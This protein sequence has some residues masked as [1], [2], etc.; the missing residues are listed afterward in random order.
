MTDWE[1]VIESFPGGSHNFPRVKGPPA[2]PEEAADQ[3]LVHHDAAHGDRLARPLH[4]LRPLDAV[5]DRRAEPA[6][7]AVPPGR[8]QRLRRHRLVR[9]RHDQ[10]PDLRAVRRSMQSR[11]S[12]KPPNLHFDRIDL[13]T[14]GARLGPQRRPAD[15]QLAGADLPDQV[16]DRYRDAEADLLQRGPLTAFG[17]G[18]FEGT[19]HYF[20]VGARA[21]RPLALA[22]HPREARREHVGFPDLRGDVLWLPDLLEVTNA[23]S[24]FL[25][26][27]ADFDYRILS[28]D[29]KSGPKRAVWDV[30]YH[31]LRSRAAHRLPEHRG[32]SAGRAAPPAT[33]ARMADGQWAQLRGD[34]ESRSRRP[35]ACSLMTRDLSRGSRG[36]E[37]SHP[38]E[39]GPFNPRAPLGYVPIAGQSPTSSIPTGS[40]SAAAGWPPKTY[41]SFDGRTAYYKASRSRSM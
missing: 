41:V 11:F 21:E 19:F 6:G 16:E 24:E 36:A 1:M 26:G 35:P 29:N 34:G 17:D 7:H 39:T 13:F 4:L 3:A 27:T 8:S 33:T 18:E 2:G 22:G 10:G 31:G 32:D 5:D 38:P 15:G 40:R 30:N 9:Q 23:K 28:L 20:S 25:G 14:D 37:A 12:M